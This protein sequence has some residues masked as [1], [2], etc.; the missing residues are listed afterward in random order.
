[1]KG[2]DVVLPVSHDKGT[3]V[4]LRAGILVQPAS[5]PEHE[6]FLSGV[7]PKGLNYS[8]P[9]SISGGTNFFALVSIDELPN[10]IGIT[11]GVVD[12]SYSDQMDSIEFPSM[13]SHTIYRLAGIPYG[14]VP[15]EWRIRS[16]AT[17]CEGLSTDNDCALAIYL[18]F[19]GSFDLNSN[20]YANEPWELYWDMAGSG[21][22]GQCIHISRAIW[23]YM[24][25]L[26]WR[27]SGTI[28]LVY[29]RFPRVAPGR[30][31]GQQHSEEREHR[32]PGDRGLAK[33]QR[34][35]RIAFKSG[36][37]LNSF[38]ACYKLN[39][40]YYPPGLR[41]PKGYTSTDDLLDDIVD[42]VILFQANSSF[43][44]AS[45]EWP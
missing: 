9:L 14:T 38:E 35:N 20:Y 7:G 3:G 8:R 10:T 31:P 39:G 30:P 34:G 21:Q 16:V 45:E 22:K 43:V 5:M 2:A 24:E 1:V 27:P 28:A 6:I 18:M 15:T 11:E 42:E 12:W 32:D 41:F 25:M 44:D 33:F 4:G 13:P 37:L 17:W 36:G 23:V 29:P 26:G 19:N 40:I